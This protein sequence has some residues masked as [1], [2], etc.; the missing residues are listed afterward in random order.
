MLMHGIS[1]KKVRTVQSLLSLISFRRNI[2][3]P[4]EIYLNFEGVFF[5]GILVITFERAEPVLHRI[6]NSNLII[7][8]P[9][10]IDVTSLAANYL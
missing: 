3:P 6:R 7:L 1:M 2:P 5:S 8:F 10:D 4:S 9:A